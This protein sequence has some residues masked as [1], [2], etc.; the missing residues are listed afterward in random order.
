MS[1]KKIFLVVGGDMR[2]VYAAKKLSENFSVYAAGFDC[3]TFNEE[4]IIFIGNL[5][6]MPRKADYILY[7]LPVSNDG[8]FVN[9]PFCENKILLTDTLDLLKDNGII[10]GGKIDP[11]TM[12][13]FNKFKAETVDY[14]KIEDFNLLN[15]VPTAE[16]AVQIAMRERNSVLY[17][18]KVLVTGYGR[19]S[20]VLIKIL[21]AMGAEVTVTARKYS[22]LQWAEVMGC[23]S[24]HLSE[25]KNNVNEYDIIFNTIPA[26]ILDKNI[27]DKIKKEAI[28]IDL[29]SKPGG[30]DFE[31]AKKFGIKTIHALALPGK[32]APVTAGEII[33]CTAF[34]ILKERRV[35]NE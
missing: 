25:F 21:H 15:A 30:V 23:K 26:M 3:R 13:I 33:A 2:Q 17:K 22:D 9:A 7:P 4:N 16:G 28:I 10:F 19:I 12:K 35:F 11:S 32:I 14:F 20:K 31:A 27:L 29:A 5:L 34:N 8:V 24:V 18:S 6:E 1:E